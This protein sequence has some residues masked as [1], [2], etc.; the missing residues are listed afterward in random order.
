[1]TDKQITEGIHKGDEYAF[2]ELIDKYQS[3][4]LN[5]SNSFLHNRHDAEDVTQEVFIEAFRSLSKF[6]GQS[7][8]STWLY[9][10]T[11]NKSLNYIRDNKKRNIMKRID[12]VFKGGTD[13]VSEPAD[14][15]EQ[16]GEA[17][18]ADNKR[19]E[20]LHKSIGTLPKNQKIAF[21][22]SNFEDLSYKQ[23]SEIMDISLASVE[24]LIHRAKKNVRKEIL[25]E[26]QKKSD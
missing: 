22:L 21:T 26:I 18:E 2:K 23:I 8:L 24:G 4:V 11:V 25:K 7:G 16:Y 14:T 6:K 3:L 1:M 17:E 20:T 9:R 5:T 12:N 10:I 19:I 15:G 13:S